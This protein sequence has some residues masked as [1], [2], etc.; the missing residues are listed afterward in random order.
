MKKAWAGRFTKETSH[1]VE[2]FTASIDIDKR[3][4]AYDIQGSIAHVKMLA[5]Q[6]IIK[7][8]EANRIIQGLKEIKDEID[9]GDFLFDIS[10]E[11]IH[12]AIEMA[13]KKKIGKLAAKLHTARSRNDQIV[14]DERLYLKD[15][16][17]NIIGLIQELRG[18]LTRLAKTYIDVIM[19]GYTHLQHA[20]PILF[21]HYLMAYTEMFRRDVERLEDCYKRVDVLPLGSCAL[22]GTAFPIDRHYVARL[23]GF[24]KVSENSIDTVSDRDFILEFL[25]AVAILAMHLSRFAEDFILWSSEEFNFIEI[26]DAFCTG[27]SIMPQKKNPDVLEL[28]RGRVGHIYGNLF[29]LLTVMKGLP[30]SYNRDMQEDK[31]PLFD[32]IDTIRP[33]LSI[34]S[35]L[36]QNIKINR[37]RMEDATRAGFLLATDL[38]DYLVVK[39]MPFREAHETVGKIVKYCEERGKNLETLSI[40]EMRNFCNLINNDVKEILDI[41]K[42]ISRRSSFGGTAPMEILRLIKKVEKQLEIRTKT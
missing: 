5:K 33:I 23:L 35:A 39:G 42:A 16:I 36:L 14:L 13:L 7:E 9:T 4:Y 24:K 41:K 30:L 11:D 19:P 22:A 18:N 21:S 27:S 10:D 15:E 38:A 28:I 37:K 25:S 34:L 40:E 31:R 32:T 26:D 8:E 12:M 3:L 29:N 20:Q 6:K 17:K 2:S 1:I